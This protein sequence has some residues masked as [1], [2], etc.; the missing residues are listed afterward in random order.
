ME[1]MDKLNAVFS[2]WDKGGP[3]RAASGPA[4][5]GQDYDKV[6]QQ[7]RQQWRAKFKEANLSQNRYRPTRQRQRG[8]RDDYVPEL[9]ADVSG[10]EKWMLKE[11]ESTLLNC[12]VVVFFG[13][14]L[15]WVSARKT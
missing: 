9:D 14:T 2:K 5:T 3:R 12:T 8:R 4:G 6:I 13:T 7:G 15:R 1:S 11:F 10:H